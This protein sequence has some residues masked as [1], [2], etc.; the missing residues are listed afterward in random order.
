MNDDETASMP[1]SALG[2]PQTSQP[3]VQPAWMRTS[4]IVVAVITLIATIYLVRL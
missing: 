3:E 1:P 4:L 2:Q